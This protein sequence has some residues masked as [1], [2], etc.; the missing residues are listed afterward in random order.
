MKRSI[1][2]GLLVSAVVLG[3]FVVQ[4]ASAGRWFKLFKVVFKTERSECNAAYPELETPPIEEG[5]T[6]YRYALDNSFFPV[7]P[8]SIFYNWEFYGSDVILQVEAFNEKGP[9]EGYCSIRTAG[10]VELVSE[11]SLRDM[12]IEEHYEITVNNPAPPMFTNYFAHVSVD[13][14][15]Y[16]HWLE[17]IHVLPFETEEENKKYRIQSLD[18]VLPDTDKGMDPVEFCTGKGIQSINDIYVPGNTMDINFT[19]LYYGDSDDQGFK[20]RFTNPAPGQKYLAGTNDSQLENDCAALEQM[21]DDSVNMSVEELVNAYGN[22]GST[23]DTIKNYTFMV[24]EDVSYFIEP[25]CWKPGQNAPDPNDNMI[26]VQEGFGEFYDKDGGTLQVDVYSTYE[27][28]CWECDPNSEII[29]DCTSYVLQIDEESY[30]YTIDY[31]IDPESCRVGRNWTHNYNIALRYCGK[32]T[33]EDTC[34]DYDKYR[35]YAGNARYNFLRD[36]SLE[37]GPYT[38]AKAPG[39]MLFEDGDNLIVKMKNDVNWYFDA[40]NKEN[41]DR[42]YFIDYIQDRY[43]NQMDFYYS[44]GL[45]TNITNDAGRYINIYYDDDKMIDYIEDSRGRKWYYTR[46]DDQ[47]LVSV[48]CPPAVSGAGSRTVQYTYTSADSDNPHQIITQ[49]DSQGQI[50]SVNYYDSQGR[51]NRQTYGQDD[52]IASYYTDPNGNITSVEV[53]DRAGNLEKHHLTETGLLDELEKEMDDGEW[54]VTDYVYDFDLDP[55]L[56][57]QNAPGHLK[58]MILPTGEIYEYEYDNYGNMTKLTHKADQN[59]VGLS[60]TYT[61]SS[62]PHS[63]LLSATDEN[64]STADFSYNGSLLEKIELPADRYF[65]PQTGQFENTRPAYQFEYTPE[66]LI[67]KITLPD[68]GTLDYEYAFAGSGAIDYLTIYLNKNAGVWDAKW[69]YDYNPQ[70]GFVE[71]VVRPQ[72]EVTSFT[73]D[74]ADRIREISNGLNEITKIAYNPSGLVSRVSSQLGSSFSENTALSYDFSYSILNQLTQ[75]T[76]SLGR[77][78][79]LGYD[80]NGKREYLK[81]P[82]AVQEGFKNLEYTYDNSGRVKSVKLPESYERG[83]NGN[84]TDFTYYGNGKLKS[85]KDPRGSTTTY[86]YD[87]YGRVSEVIMPDGTAEVFQ[88]DGTGNLVKH[89]KSSDAVYY[90]DYYSNGLLRGKS[91]KIPESQGDQDGVIQLDDSGIPAMMDSQNWQTVQDSTSFGGQFSQSIASGATFPMQTSISKDAYL[92]QVYYPAGITGTMNVNIF[93]GFDSSSPKFTK[94]INLASGSESWVNVGMCEFE[95]EQAAVQ[96]EQVSGTAAFDAVRLVP[97]TLYK[98]D[99]MG[100]LVSAG[101]CEFEYDSAGNLVKEIDAFGREISREYYPGGKLKKLVYPDGYFVTY[102]YDAAGRLETIT[103]SNNELLA[104]YQRD[105]SGRTTRKLTVGGAETFY[106]YEDVGS[107]DDD[108]GIYLEK[109]SY[110][111][112]GTNEMSVE[113]TRDPAGNVVSRSQQQY[114][115]NFFY[116]KNYWLTFADGVDYDYNNIL[117]RESETEN[118][119]TI[120]YSDDGDGM[121]RFTSV[122]SDQVQYDGNG[123]IKVFGDRQFIYDN[124]NRLIGEYSLTADPNTVNVA[125]YNYDAFGRRISK[126]IGTGALAE[127]GQLTKTFCYDGRNVI[128]E[129]SSEGQVTSRY[130]Y[131]ENGEEIITMINIERPQNLLDLPSA[132]QIAD[133]WLSLPEDSGYIAGANFA[134]PNRIDLADLAVYMDTSF[135]AEYAAEIEENYFGYYLD[136]QGSVVGVYSADS[137]TGGIKETYRYS[138]FGEYEIFDSTGSQVAEPVTGNPYMFSGFRLDEETDF[139]YVGSRCYNPKLGIYMSRDPQRKIESMNMYDFCRNNPLSGNDD[140]LSFIDSVDPMN[141]LGIFSDI[142]KQRDFGLTAGLD[143]VDMLPSSRAVSAMKKLGVGSGLQPQA[144][145][146]GELRNPKNPDACIPVD[147]ADNRTEK[148]FKAVPES[149]KGEIDKVMK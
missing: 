145:A 137:S 38:C 45:L 73:Y 84:K 122:G 66:G 49:E 97:C 56:S 15:L 126:A 131:G 4:N 5:L 51:I 76:D 60:R 77:I 1:L 107:S 143:A 37:S 14:F 52:F 29:S 95:N 71:K 42:T 86:H 22:T 91:V 12:D 61:Y 116:D 8:N 19:R 148:L 58:K 93:D 64:G 134:D 10:G 20:R 90:Y 2:S 100:R 129:Y 135:D 7:C 47:D 70:T 57:E 16:H 9:D 13:S 53:Y 11:G 141:G 31:G 44:D 83:P 87:N 18:Q 106:D 94:Q 69:E 118:G 72:G 81:D 24:V 23:S 89:K 67:S 138:A 27:H 21:K 115:Q 96:F 124:E 114:V 32:E 109:I 80:P 142:A 55:Q 43:G 144:A 62:G 36:N 120:Q 140:Y 17:N 133:S 41:T 104:Y 74:N 26:E 128:A 39:V 108:M 123:N 85:I 63:K 113:Y 82:K 79:Q 147:P 105:E 127:E 130:V 33:D 50:W 46:N 121:G 40:S 146:S 132:S 54:A 3:F 119:T 35:L 102:A 34:I 125:L 149:F 101:K 99:V 117:Q 78:T 75:I 30:T 28:F 103:D 111:F 92:V 48:Q 110:L 59:D 136:A 68:A 25:D 139:Y 6:V 112:A 98:Y 88:Y 65:K